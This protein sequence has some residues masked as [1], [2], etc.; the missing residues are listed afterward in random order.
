MNLLSNKEYENKFLDNFECITLLY[1]QFFKYISKYSNTMY[2]KAEMVN[3]KS[4]IAMCIVLNDYLKYFIE[5]YN[6]KSFFNE[7]IK[8]YTKMCG[9][10]F[11][12]QNHLQCHM[13]ACGYARWLRGIN[14]SRQID[15]NISIFDSLRYKLID[16]CEIFKEFDYNIFVPFI[17]KY[18]IPHL[19]GWYK[20]NKNNDNYW[21]E[22]ENRVNINPSMSSI[23]HWELKNTKIES[24]D[25]NCKQTE[26]K[27]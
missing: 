19:H 2:N 21:K 9:H 24:N 27:E 16:D 18:L 11:D 23:M 3:K 17:K 20:M 7:I 4:I 25:N 15:K 1:D 22:W 26:A 8:E 5:T 13:L 10:Q 12:P 6:N 14:S